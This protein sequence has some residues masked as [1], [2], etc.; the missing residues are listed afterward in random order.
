LLSKVKLSVVM[1][2]AIIS[3]DVLPNVV[4]LKGILTNFVVMW[5]FNG[6]T[7]YLMHPYTFV[8]L[9]IV[10]TLIGT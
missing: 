8:K 3:N 6:P 1:P 9:F 5:Y 2:S 4:M 7:Y 10:K